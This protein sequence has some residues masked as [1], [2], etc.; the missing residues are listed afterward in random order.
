[1]LFV[2][3]VWQILLFVVMVGIAI[4]QAPCRILACIPHSVIQVIVCPCHLFINK[5]VFIGI[6]LFMNRTLLTTVH[7]HCASLMSKMLLW[8]MLI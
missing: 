2:K 4:S 6:P 7:K 5:L 3:F 1:M 8:H